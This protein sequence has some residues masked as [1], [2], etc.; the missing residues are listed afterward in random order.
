MTFLKVNFMIVTCDKYFCF[1]AGK[2][3]ILCFGNS[4]DFDRYLLAVSLC[5]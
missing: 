2:Y 1:I 4:T 5:D 3:V